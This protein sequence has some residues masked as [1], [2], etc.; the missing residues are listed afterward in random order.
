MGKEIL[1]SVL[2][3]AAPPAAAY[4]AGQGIV[5]DD[6]TSPVLL[7]ALAVAVYGASQGWSI[8]RKIINKPRET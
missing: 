4:L 5:I 2:R 7:V 6:G 3:H 8:A 1:L